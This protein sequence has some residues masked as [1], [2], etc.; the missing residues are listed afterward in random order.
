MGRF[1]NF[2]AIQRLLIEVLAHQ[3]TVVHSAFSSLV[4]AQETAF[5][6][7]MVRHEEAAAV[8]DAVRTSRKGTGAPP[9]KPYTEG[10]CSEMPWPAATGQRMLSL[11]PKP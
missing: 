5:A 8:G 2:S 10:R 4:G 7:P 3:N 9:H 1:E 11:I 6:L